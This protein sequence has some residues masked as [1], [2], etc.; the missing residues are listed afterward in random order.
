MIWVRGRIVGD[1]ELRVSVLDRTF[2]HGLGLFETFR[3]WKGHPTLLPRHLDRLGRSANELGL[4]LERLSVPDGEAVRSLLLADGRQGDAMLRIT[5]SGGLTGS[6]G[7]TLWMRSFPLPPP[8]REG[9]IVLG[10]AWPSR[11]DPLA[12]Y[13]TLNY[14]PNRLMFEDAR[15]KEFDE[16]VTITP[17]GNLWEGSRSNL[18]VVVGGELLTPPCGGAGGVLPGVMRALIL[19]RAAR[20]GLEAREMPLG[21]FDRLFRPEEVFLSNSVRGIM[22]VGR[23]GEARYPAPGPITLRLWDEILPWLESG[24]TTT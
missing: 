13:K 2:E 12:G 16:C 3:T 5:L 20:I 23:W 9:G 17:D 8:V 19:E 18:F 22:P 1:D 21:L 24:G 4:P 14:W 10:P 15:A 11:V 7:S 6:H